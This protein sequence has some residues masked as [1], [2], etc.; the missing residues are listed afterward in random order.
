MENKQLKGEDDIMVT[1]NLD[2]LALKMVVPIQRNY[3][4]DYYNAD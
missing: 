2:V 1:L 3:Q 4:L